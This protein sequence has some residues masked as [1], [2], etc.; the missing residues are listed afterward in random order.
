M[1]RRL[2]KEA[3]VSGVH[4]HRLRHTFAVSFLRAGEDTFTLKYLLGHSSLA[5][6]QNYLKS[7]NAE[8]VDLPI[9]STTV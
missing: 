9:I 6:V 2:G 5:R 3:G 7:L 4:V 8:V 1:V